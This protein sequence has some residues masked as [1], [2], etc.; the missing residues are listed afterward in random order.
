MTISTRTRLADT[1]GILAAGALWTVLLGSFLVTVGGLIALAGAAAV[2][3]MG[4]DRLR[5][6]FRREGV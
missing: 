5:Q 6:H 3:L 2:C 1:A 4:L